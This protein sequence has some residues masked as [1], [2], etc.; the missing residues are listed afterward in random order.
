MKNFRRIRRRRRLVL[1]ASVLLVTGVGVATIAAAMSRF[2]VHSVPVADAA[3]EPSPQPP[4]TVAASILPAPPAAAQPAPADQA[5]E[6][7]ALPYDYASPVP[8]SDAAADDYF[9][10]ALFLGNSITDG[11]E[12]FGVIKNATVYAKNGL[13]VTDALT[14]PVVRQGQGRISVQQALGSQQFGKVYLMFGMNELG[15]SSESEFTRRY[16]NLIEE[17][18]RLQPNAV[19]YVQSILPVTAEK[20]A[21]DPVF[22]NEKVD[23]FNELLRALCAENHALYLDA[24]S[25]LADEAGAL[26]ADAS[27]DGVH[28]TKATYATW[29]DYIRTHTWGGN[30]K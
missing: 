23:R 5:E 7:K 29:F 19:V 13:T 25:A 24:H 21:K 22:T 6:P 2:P 12:R 9:D 30:K 1:A 15:W 16:G 3:G 27:T 20:S 26:P 11:I 28:I 18:W 10:D 17:I 14:E 4:E 8:P